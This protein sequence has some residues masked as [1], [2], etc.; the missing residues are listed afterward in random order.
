MRQ[1]AKGNEDI[2]KRRLNMRTI[3]SGG[4]EL[5]HIPSYLRIYKTKNAQFPC[6][7]GNKGAEPLGATCWL[8]PTA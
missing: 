6:H 5:S 4:L 8:L 3:T 2:F 1:K 7:S